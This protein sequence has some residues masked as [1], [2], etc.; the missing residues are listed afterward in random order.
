[1]SHSGPRAGWG[2]TRARVLALLRENSPRRTTDMVEALNIE[3]ASIWVHLKRLRA[4]GQV[5][6]LGKCR[7]ATWEAV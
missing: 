4:E 3:Q 6:M 7:N 5:R 2:V 1:M